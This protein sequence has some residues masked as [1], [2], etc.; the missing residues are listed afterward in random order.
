M[1]FR[2]LI[3]WIVLSIV[4][5]ACGDKAANEKKLVPDQP[6]TIDKT[7]EE[8]NEQAEETVSDSTEE[9]IEV[10][11]LPQTL[12][13]LAA[14]PPGYVDYLGILR[15]EE[16]KQIDELTKDLPD[17]SEEPSE[18]QLDA[19]YND[20]LA[21]FQQDFQGPEDL[22]AQ[23][24]FQTIGD[25]DIDDPRK[26]FKENLNVLVLL[27]AS[28]SMRADL[29]GQ[30]QMDA[31]KK[32][33]TNFMKGLPKDANVGLRIYGHKGTGSNSDKEL[34]CSSSELVYPLAPYDQSAF[35]SSL[36]KTQPA[37]WTPIQLALNEA[38]KDL[39]PFKGEA[40][41]NIVY[42]VSDGISTCDDDPVGAAKSLYNSDITP[43]VNVIGFNIDHEGQKQ[44]KEVAKATEGTYQDVQ[45]AESLQKELDQASEIAKKW[46][47][48][49]KDKS[50]RLE[51]DRLKNWNDIWDYDARQFRKWVDERQQVGFAM[52]YLY[53]TRELMSSESYDY[54]QQK[55]R[56]YHEWIEAEY[57]KLKQD[58]YEMNDKK[59]DEAIQ[60]LEEK[61]TENAPE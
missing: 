10:A 40:N 8:E 24:K 45:N 33:I 20:L 49:K 55:N 47:D 57:T 60:M 28:G 35:Q 13:E 9:E 4:L 48:W 50:T 58:L 34:S 59:I 44:L 42:L 27:D 46:A 1:K 32:A 16:Q 18:L 41:T 7:I 11:P 12:S 36:D 15:P 6:I 38:Q 22:I 61:Y 31:A 30:T 51:I 26:Q 19:Y 5:T 2:S 52:Q 14:L 56:D 43:I 25:P 21:I 3:L 53:Q 54:L 29:G 23:L 17:I 39:A 37:G